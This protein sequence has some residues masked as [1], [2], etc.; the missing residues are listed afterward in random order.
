MAK[1][2]EDAE[3]A[4]LHPLLKERLHGK[5]SVFTPGHRIKM[6]I[7]PMFLN[8][9]VPWGMF[10]F[11][12]AT[13]SFWMMYSKPFLAYAL[14]ALC[15]LFWVVTVFVAINKRK[16]DPSP[17]W[18][19]YFSIMIAVAILSGWL[20][21]NNIYNNYS[22]HYYEAKDLKLIDHLDAGKEH[23]QNVMDAGMFYFEHGNGL[24]MYRSWHFKSR[25]VY[26][27]SPVVRMVDNDHW[28]R[29]GEVPETQSFDFWAVGKDCCSTAT[30]DFRCGDY[31]NPMT[32]GG[33]RV[34]KEKD[35]PFYRLAVEQA[36]SLY[37]IQARNPIFFEWTLNPLETVNS[38][39]KTAFDHYIRAVI[40][41]FIVSLFAV[42]MASCKF[43]CM[44]RAESVYGEEIFGDQKWKM[45]GYRQQP[46]DLHVRTS[47]V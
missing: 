11:I 7:L 29:R 28:G 12:L 45:G 21:G 10:V 46:K 30:S 33:V 4:G 23:G 8:V 15:V 3:A 35:L 41:G 43:S 39:N 26:C 17:T 44:G 19:W 42:S 24:D 38:W 18:Y 40:F 34:L 9:F 2:A 6:N 32:R 36:K 47:R 31:L 25:T 14:V 13:C 16:Y 27:V 20:L 37:G 5:K 22:R 1:A